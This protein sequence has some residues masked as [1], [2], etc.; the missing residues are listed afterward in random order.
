ME[1]NLDYLYDR[2]VD[3]YSCK[4][5]YTT[6]KVLSRYIRAHNHDTDFCSF[7]VTT[8]INPLLYYVHVCPSCGFSSTE[9]SSNYFP[10]MTMEA[11]QEKISTNWNNKFYCDE[12]SLETAINSYKLAIYCATIKKEKN[13]A[14]AGLYL[15]LSW[16]YRTEE[17]NIAEEQRFIRL[18]L[19]EYLKSYMNSDYSETHLSEVKL[20]YIIGELSRRVDNHVQ[21]TRYFSRVI[22]KQK[23][24]VEKGIV[25]MAKDRWSEMREQKSG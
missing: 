8:K 10:P 14:L 7:Y 25:Q 12:R 22:E 19:E 17:I 21:A 4:T 23:D 20:L 3:C 24:T 15:R 5:S 18:A 11:I 1:K 6:K 2:K 16:L 9:E 13:I